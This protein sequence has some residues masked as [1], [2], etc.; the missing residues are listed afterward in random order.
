MP[1]L[2]KYAIAIW[3]HDILA[4]MFPDFPAKR[5]VEWEN[6]GAKKEDNETGFFANISC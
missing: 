3:D 4:A 5:K 1:F 2:R 6:T